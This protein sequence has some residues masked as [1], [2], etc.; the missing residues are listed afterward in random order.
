MDY[1]ILVL[2]ILNSLYIFGF[3]SAT[4]YGL[5]VDKKP[6]PED[7]EILWF[8]GWHLRNAPKW[9]QNPICYCVV[10][11][12]SVHSWPYILFNYELTFLNG[13]TYIIYIF[14]LS[15]FNAIVNDKLSS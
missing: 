15:G 10:C 11:M 5:D 6:D 1:D 12:A 4:D 8:I 9:I 13:A 7:R 3:S 14:A 2:L